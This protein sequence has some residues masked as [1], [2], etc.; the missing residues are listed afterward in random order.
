[1]DASAD[2]TRGYIPDEIMRLKARVMFEDNGTL[3]I[4]DCAAVSRAEGNPDGGAYVAAWVWV[5]DPVSVP[6]TAEECADPIQGVYNRAYNARLIADA[7]QAVEEIDADELERY[8]AGEDKSSL[9]VPEGEGAP[10]P[11]WGPDGYGG[12]D[13]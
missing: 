4:D 1:M 3:E 5:P 7:A 13:C 9:T 8:A 11:L 12:F 6:Y 2:Q 10:D